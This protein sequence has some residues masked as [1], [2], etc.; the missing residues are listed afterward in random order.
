MLAAIATALHRRVRAARD[1]GFV[2]IDALIALGVMGAVAAGFAVS[3]TNSQL[4][5]RASVNASQATQLAQGVI[6][7]ARSTP[8][9]K[10][11]TNTA[12]ATGMLTGAQSAIT[13]SGYALVPTTTTQMR[14]TPVTVQTAVGWASTPTAGAATSG[15]GTKIVIVKV[16]WNDRT[17]DGQAHTHLET[18]T[19]TPG[20]GEVAPSKVRLNDGTLVPNVPDAPT[21]AGALVSGPGVQVTWSSMPTATSYRLAYSINGGDWQLQ[22]TVGTTLTVNAPPQASISIHVNAINAVGASE[23]SN[24]VTMT[25]PAVPAT[26]TVTGTLTDATHATF[27]WPAIAGADAYTVESSV[28]SGAF[29]TAAARQQATTITL[30]GNPGQTLNARVRTIAGVMTSP[31]SNTASVALPLVAAPTVTGTGAAWSQN[32]TF[33]W[34]TISGATGYLVEKQ[35]GT[36]AWT[37]AAA[38]QTGTSISVTGAWNQPLAV[39]VKALQGPAASDYSNTATVSIGAQPA[40]PS[41]TQIGSG[42]QTYRVQGAGDFDGDGRDDVLGNDSTDKGLYLYTR[43]SAGWKSTHVQI[44]SGWSTT[45][46]P[47]LIGG[48]DWNK[49][50]KQDVAVVD[51]TGALLNYP[52]TGTIA[53][54]G[55]FGTA[56]TMGNSGWGAYT[57]VLYPGDLNKDGNPDLLAI[58][59]AGDLFFYAGDGKNGFA[60]GI[61]VGPGWNNFTYVVPIKDLDGDGKMDLLGVKSTGELFFYQGKGTGGTF[62]SAVQVPRTTLN[63]ASRWYGLGDLDGDGI[64]DLSEINNQSSS[65][66]YGKLFLWDGATIRKALQQG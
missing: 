12:P 60:P 1:R 43:N 13:G 52:G 46:L 11:G 57:Q 9:A 14:G 33:T 59:S 51:S 53:S 64:P 6:E 32:A 18:A 24:T 27:T 47:Q 30:S 39:R 42:W 45:N 61:K 20:I 36:T 49:D 41:S 56:V 31:N 19:V 4:I 25:M 29:T 62:A 2:L 38:N 44:G 3:A 23:D 16:T 37:T 66:D 7:T 21:I 50:G 26:P 28:D 22:S 15:F 8:W 63:G 5:Q 10:L 40:V 35:V 58:N 65:A 34:N 17:G 48:A 54:S 55:T